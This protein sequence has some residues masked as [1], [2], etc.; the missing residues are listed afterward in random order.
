M[1][2]QPLTLSLGSLTTVGVIVVI[3]LI[4]IAMALRFRTE[5]LRARTGTP[6]MDEVAGAVQE[7]A[8]AYLRRQLRTLAVFAVIAFLLLLLLPTHGA[9]DLVHRLGAGAGPQH[10]GAEAQRHRDRD[11]GD[12]HDHPHRGETA[13]GERDGIGVHEVLRTSSCSGVLPGAG[14]LARRRADVQTRGSGGAGPGR[15]ASAPQP[16]GDLLE[17]GGARAQLLQLDRKSVV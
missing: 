3:A 2:P 14:T 8:A 7:G 16:G 1:N 15:R 11:Q 4:A 10:L 5:V 13:Q 9:G 12:H 6:A 17:R